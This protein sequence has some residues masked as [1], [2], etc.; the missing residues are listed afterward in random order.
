[1]KWLALRLYG[2]LQLRLADLKLKNIASLNRYASVS[3]DIAQAVPFE[4]PLELR[5]SKSL[6]GLAVSALPLAWRD[7]DIEVGGGHP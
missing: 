6:L 3:L 7:P 4:A 1:L 2:C 5:L